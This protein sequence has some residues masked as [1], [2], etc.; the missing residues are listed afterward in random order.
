MTSSNHPPYKVDMSREPD[1]PS[2]D[3][4]EKMLPA[5][6]ADKSLTAD[7]M[8]HFAYADKYLAEFVEKMMAKYPNSLFIITGDHADR[9]TLDPSP[10]DYE[11]VAVPLVLIGPSVAGK[12]LPAHAAAA[13]MDVAATTLELA[14]PKGTSYYAFGQN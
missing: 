6:T 14:L 12:K 7:R 11:R 9:W 1:L 13:H 8:W 2:V 3:A 10:S 5:Q 4:L